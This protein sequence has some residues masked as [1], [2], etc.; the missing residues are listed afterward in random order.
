M[1]A[2]YYI[3]IKPGIQVIIIHKTEVL[4]LEN[5]KNLELGL[6]KT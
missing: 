4:K 2:I 5:K 1:I 3:C 6:V